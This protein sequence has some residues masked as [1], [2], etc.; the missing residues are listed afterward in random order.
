MN[1]LAVL[2]LVASRATLPTTTANWL[3]NPRPPEP[4]TIGGTTQ[5]R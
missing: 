5:Y 3:K 1:C 2:E 4:S